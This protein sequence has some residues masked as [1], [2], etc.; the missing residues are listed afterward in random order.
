[1][2]RLRTQGY[3]RNTLLL[4]LLVPVLVLFFASSCSNNPPS[5]K[6]GGPK[7]TAQ[8]SGAAKAAPGKKPAAA[9]PKVV[10]GSVLETMDVASYTY[11]RIKEATGGEVWVAGPKTALKVG[12]AVEIPPGQEMNNFKSSTLK[13]TFDRLI[14]VSSFS[15]TDKKAPGHG[16]MGGK[17]PHG[18][19]GGKGPHGAMGGKAP[20]GAK[21]GKNPHAGMAGTAPH[22]AKAGGMANAMANAMEGKPG[23]GSMP[24]G[25]ASAKAEADKSGPIAAGSIAKAAGP[26]GRTVAEVFA[27]SAAL[28]GKQVKIRAKVVKVSKGIMGHNWFHLRDGSGDKAAGTHDLTVTSDGLVAKGATVLVSGTVAKDKDFG[29]GYLYKVIVEKATLTAET[30]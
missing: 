17:G 19:M 12:Q 3:S 28:A 14:M 2:L 30:P 16:A 10:K 25:M 27:Q 6:A 24:T 23:A 15:A 13:R 18:A 29:A 22:G 26:D 8:A 11:A 7:A 4:S 21:D 20:H 1:M 9:A 5:T